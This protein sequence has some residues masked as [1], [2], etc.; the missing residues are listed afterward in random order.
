LRNET[1]TQFVLSTL[2]E[3]AEKVVAAHERS[4]LSDRDRDMFLKLLDSSPKPNKA[5]K[6][7]AARYGKRKTG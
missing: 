1:L 5:L 3:A 4:V 6:G 2:S 7:A